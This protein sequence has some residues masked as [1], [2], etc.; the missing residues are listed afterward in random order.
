MS[1]DTGT[2]TE[3]EWHALRAK[4][5]GASEIACLFYEWM[6]ADGKTVY[7]HMF[8]TPP[9]GAA[10]LG[11]VSRH[12]TG[13]RLYLEKT[14]Q[15]APDEVEGERIDAGVHLEPGLAAW[16]QK[17]WGPWPLRKASYSKHPTIAGFGASRDY[18]E[19]A[20]PH[21]PV[22]FKNVDYLIFRDNWHADDDEILAPPID[23]TLQVQHQMAGTPAPEG[24]IVA[25]VG[26]NSLKRGKILRHEPTIKKIEAAVISF[27]AAVN[28]GVQPLVPDVDTVVDLY[29]S[30]VKGREIDLTGDN[31]APELCAKYVAAKKI[32]DD[33][34]FQVG[35]IKAQ[36]A[37]KMGV[38]TKARING[39]TITWPAIHREEKLIPAK[40]QRALDYRGGFTVRAV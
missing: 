1:P 7:L 11:C 13:Y 5:V 8:E 31:E 22:E 10:C 37:A 20:A 17:K 34:E 27:W 29:A 35:Q 30:G 39:F 25:C 24:W 32:Y 28:A 18:E 38:H 4:N 21:R 12:K 26:G 14:G 2:L 16:A 23:I 6:L 36:L 3:Q 15:L 9:E 40:M 19:A 33:A